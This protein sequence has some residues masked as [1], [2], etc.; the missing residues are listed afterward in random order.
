[1]IKRIYSASVFVSDSDQAYDFY[2]NKLGFTVRLDM[3][4]GTYRWLEVA[5]PNTETALTLA[6]A[7]DSNRDKLGI[8]TGIILEADDIDATYEEL[9]AKGVN[10]TQVPEQQAWG[11]KMAI[12]TDLDGNSFVLNSVG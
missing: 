1:M 6:P 7:E 8:F 4:L 5:P 3:T 10:F 9:K 11:K 12:F 2:V